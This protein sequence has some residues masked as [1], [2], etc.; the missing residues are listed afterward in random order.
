MG[1]RT[2]ME[3]H[4]CIITIAD[5]A[6]INVGTPLIKPSISEG[7]H[8]TQGALREAVKVD[9]PVM[10]WN[11]LPNNVLVNFEAALTITRYALQGGWDGAD[12]LNDF[13]SNP[14]DVSGALVLNRGIIEYQGEFDGIFS[15][16][17]AITNR[18]GGALDLAY[19]VSIFNEVG[20]LDV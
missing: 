20:I 8:G 15:G 13:S 10:V 12:F 9:R 5:N 3:Q 4:S 2:L 7:F 17:L 14:L 11:I 1:A 18:S 16:Q 19:T 6:T